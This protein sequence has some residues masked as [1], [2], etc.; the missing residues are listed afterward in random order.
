V[1][2]HSNY[3]NRII[4]IVSLFFGTPCISQYVQISR[5]LHLLFLNIWNTVLERYEMECTRCSGTVFSLLYICVQPGITIL[6]SYSHNKAYNDSLLFVYPSMLLQRFY[7]LILPNPGVQIAYN[8][9]MSKYS[10]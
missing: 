9:Y 3:N 8:K 6:I 2:G 7:S 5:L 4:S 10:G 1:L